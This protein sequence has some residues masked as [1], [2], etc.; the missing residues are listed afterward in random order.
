MTARRLSLGIGLVPMASA[1]LLAFWSVGFGLP[2]VFRPDEDVMVGRA[3]RMAT[4]GSLDP[5][6]PNYPPLVFYVFAAVLK[7]TGHLASA[8]AG[9]PS[10]SYLAARSVS[11]VAQIATA[12]LVFLAGRMAYGAISG[13]VAAT[14][15]AVAPLAVRQAHFATTDAVQVALMAAAIAAALAARSRRGFV[16]AGALCG[17]AASAKYTGGIVMAGRRLVPHVLVAAAAVFAAA[18]AVIVIHP[19]G[20]LSGLAFLGAN[21]YSR[22]GDLPIGLIYHPTVTLPVGLGLG[23]Y[24]MAVAGMALGLLRRERHDLALLAFS[25]AHLALTGFGHEVFFRYMLPLLPALALLAGGLLRRARPPAALLAL[26]LLA[27]GAYASIQTD[28]LLGRTDTRQLAA[29]WLDANVPAGSSIAS[30]YYGGPYYDA[31]QVRQNRRYVDDE[32]AAGF[33]QGRFTDR[34]RINGERPEYTLKASG[35]PWQSPAAAGGLVTF[36]AARPGGLY[37]PLDSF[38]LPIWGLERVDRPGPSISIFRNGG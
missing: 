26:L 4:E 25:G 13:F 16:L 19:Y 3:V 1:A 24:G 11:A 27:P 36:A 15:V 38:Y 28:V 30:P 7:L 14:A 17:L 32:L 23:A 6:F 10:P 29:A 37:D 22:G 12:G 20:Y 9:D 33:L 31:Q 34:Y 2:F 35:P 18:G 8:T 5:L 21:A